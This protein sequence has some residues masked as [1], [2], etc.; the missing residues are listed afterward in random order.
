MNNEFMKGFIVGIIEGEGHISYSVPSA[1]QIIITNT[2]LNLLITT[3]QFLNFLN[4][5]CSIK[6]YNKD[7]I[8]KHPHWNK[9]FRIFIT[10]R[11]NFEKLY[12]LYT[13]I[14]TRK[15]SELH[16]LLSSYIRQK[17]KPRKVRG[18]A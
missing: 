11:E 12:S 6:E 4:I 14:D 2:D 10:H 8:K 16:K 13:G 3:K 1:R 7:T 17:Y 5:S 18:T 9:A 15:K